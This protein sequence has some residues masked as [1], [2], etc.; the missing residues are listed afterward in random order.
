MLIIS[1]IQGVGDYGVYP[2]INSDPSDHP[3]YLVGKHLHSNAHW[4]QDGSKVL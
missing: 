4:A 2:Y 1:P 3:R